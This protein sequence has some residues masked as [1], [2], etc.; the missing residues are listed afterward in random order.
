MITTIPATNAVDTIGFVMVTV[1]I[2]VTVLV[3]VLVTVEV[4]VV[5]VE[6]VIV[7]VVTG[8]YGIWKYEAAHAVLPDSASASLGR[9]HIVDT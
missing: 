4:V 1:L 5:A 9:L 3:T 6:V 7:V 8:V 2:V